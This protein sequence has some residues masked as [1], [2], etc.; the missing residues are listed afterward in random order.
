MRTRPCLR[1]SRRSG[2]QLLPLVFVAVLAGAA[3]LWGVARAGWIGSDDVTGVQG[4]PVQR[5]PLKIT[6]VER[7]NLK[8]AD[9]VSLKSEIEGMTTILFLIPEGTIVEEG[10]LLCELDATELID[11]RFQ[12]EIS[13]RNA[14]AAYIKA[15]Q[16][17][18]IQKSQNDSD[19]KK[20]EQELYFAQVD[21]EKFKEGERKAKEAESDPKGKSS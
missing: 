21:L 7:G 18:E 10:T 8:A 17:Y 1:K 15:K 19:I 20:A 13:L 6:V 16:T 9:S 5:G 12:Q 14:E 2:I 3:V 11:K 4:A